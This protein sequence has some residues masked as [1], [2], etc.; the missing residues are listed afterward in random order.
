MLNWR[1]VWSSFSSVVCP[2][3]YRRWRFSALRRL[4]WPKLCVQNEVEPELLLLPEFLGLRG[5]FLDIGANNG[6]YI[7]AT[8][9]KKAA[10]E[11]VA[12]EPI[13]RLVRLLKRAFPGVSVHNLALTES[14]GMRWL[15]IPDIGG[16]SYATRATLNIEQKET[17]ETG[18][19]LIRVPTTT[20]DAFWKSLGDPPL[21]CVKIDTEGHEFQV[22]KGG[23]GVLKRHRPVLMVEIE[24][25]HHAG[26]EVR[27]IFA[28]VEALGY[29]TCHFDAALPGLKPLEAYPTPAGPA[30]ANPRCLNNYFF[31]PEGSP[32]CLAAMERVNRRAAAAAAPAA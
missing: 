25:R 29:R 10:G 3:V 28:W 31:L 26:G 20:L 4:S 23:Q 16:R 27:E 30:V 9:G 13:P 14:E 8:L 21:A 19:R 22:L 5:S 32:A 6:E 2:P 7:L 1:I 17:G 15:K 18:R 11:I 12:V 24:P